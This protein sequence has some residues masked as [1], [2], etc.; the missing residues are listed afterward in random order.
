[1]KSLEQVEWKK[2]TEGKIMTAQEQALRTQNRK[3]ID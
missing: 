1:M 3:T 2:E